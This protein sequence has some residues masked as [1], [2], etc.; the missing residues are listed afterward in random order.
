MKR[1]LAC[2]LVA[3]GACGPQGVSPVEDAQIRDA[4]LDGGPPLPA[5]LEPPDCEEFTSLYAYAEAP[6]EASAARRVVGATLFFPGE[7]A[8]FFVLPDQVEEGE[9]RPLGPDGPVF[10]FLGTECSSGTFESCATTWAPTSGRAYLERLGGPG[11]ELRWVIADLLWAPA[12][13]E[14]SEVRFTSER[15]CRFYERIDLGGTVVGDPCATE[16][17]SLLCELARSAR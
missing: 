8:A 1:W 7:V 10:A 2:A 5:P 9:L 4:E 11:E 16:P 17:A 14:G 3:L 12:R 15:R 6:R 13:R